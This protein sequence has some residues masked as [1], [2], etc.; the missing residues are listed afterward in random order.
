MTQKQELELDLSS[1]RKCVYSFFALAASDPRSERWARLQDSAFQK[2]SEEAAALLRE[3]ARQVEGDSAPGELPPD[4]LDLA[5]LVKH[6]AASWDEVNEAYESVFGLLSSKECP[7]YETSYYPQTFSVFRSQ[8]VADV[9]GFYQAF[10]VEPSRD[11]PERHDH[12]AL[13]LEFMAWLIAKEQN[14]PD[15]EK[16]EITREAQRK[17]FEDHLAWWV[18]AFA[19]ALRRKADGV[20]GPGDLAAPAT[21]LLGE[22]GRLLAAFVQVERRLLNI[23]P[24]TELVAPKDTDGAETPECE[25]CELKG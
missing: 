14:A 23:K 10:G 24:P 21:S 2:A 19:L 6:V 4:Q 25:G 15:E 20:S 7:P 1:A 12:L 3:Q 17:F 22:L 13:E 18:P 16:A 5:S 9:A 11:K 8:K